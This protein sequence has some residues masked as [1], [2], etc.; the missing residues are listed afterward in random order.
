M[1]F[2]NERLNGTGDMAEYYDASVQINEG[3]FI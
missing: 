1:V 2:R 3:Y